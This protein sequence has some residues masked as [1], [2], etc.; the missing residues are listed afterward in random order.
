MAGGS[1]TIS[2]REDRPVIY[3]EATRQAQQGHLNCTVKGTLT[4]NASSTTFV[5][6]TCSNNSAILP[7]PL[8]ADAAAALASGAL[9]FVPAPRQFTVN[10]PNNAQVDKTFV[11]VI[12]G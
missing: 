12:I 6:Q 1:I 9:W 4:P 7:C 8:T 3:T 11:F 5:A 10:H 2:N